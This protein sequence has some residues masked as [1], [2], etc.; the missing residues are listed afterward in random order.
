MVISLICATL[1]MQRRRRLATWLAALLAL[2]LLVFLFNAIFFPDAQLVV[3]V[4]RA[5]GTMAGRTTLWST[6]WTLFL[7]APVLGHGPHTFGVFHK[8]PWV[9]NLYLEVLTEQ[10][11]IG[12]MA[13]GVLLVYGFTVAWKLQRAASSD[14]VLFGAGAFAGLVGFCSAAVVELS[15]VRE[16]V[17]IILFVLLGVIARLSSINREIGR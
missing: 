11:I 17:V 10:G 13:L 1:L 5:W 6:A 12:L 16:W 8:I 9:H 7:D 14:T 3:K 15:F 4:V 2:L